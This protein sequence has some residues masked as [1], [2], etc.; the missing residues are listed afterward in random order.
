MNFSADWMLLIMGV[1]M[2]IIGMILLNDINKRRTKTMFLCGLLSMILGIVF[3]VMP[4]A[5]YKKSTSAESI[6]AVIND[7]KLKTIR[8]YYSSTSYVEYQNVVKVELA[9]SDVIA[10]TTKDGLKHVLRPGS[11]LVEVTED[12][13]K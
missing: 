2:T 11:N 9:D 8:A 5:H 4:I 12:V 1:V 3:V 7:N 10:F 13:D 6:I